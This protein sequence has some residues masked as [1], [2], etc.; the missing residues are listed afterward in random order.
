MC[1]SYIDDLTTVPYIG[2]ASMA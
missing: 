2:E 1:K